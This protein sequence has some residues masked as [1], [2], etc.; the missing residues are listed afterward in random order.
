MHCW[1]NNGQRALLVTMVRISVCVLFGEARPEMMGL[2][3]IEVIRT[4]AETPDES[5]FSVVK[6]LI[7]LLIESPA[8][9]DVCRSSKTD[10]PSSDT[11]N[12]RPCKLL[13]LRPCHRRVDGPA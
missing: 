8:E 7:C 3:V 9:W 4:P 2:I 11:R 13:E 6:H 10:R 1:R 5:V 12:E